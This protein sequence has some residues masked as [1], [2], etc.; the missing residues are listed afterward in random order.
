M[1]L[2]YVIFQWLW[3]ALAINLSLFYESPTNDSEIAVD[4]TCTQVCHDRDSLHLNLWILAAGSTVHIFL[5][6]VIFFSVK[7]P[8]SRIRR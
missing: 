4:S 3:L 8:E 6:A 1:V 5:K 7:A 2:H